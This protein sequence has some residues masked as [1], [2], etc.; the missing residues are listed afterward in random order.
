VGLVARLLLGNGTLTVP[1]RDELAAEGL[2]LLEE[3]LK[4]SVRYDHFK[5]PGRRFNGKVTLVRVA[6]ALSERRVVV[7]ASSG[8]SKLVDSPYTSP[9]FGMVEIARHEDRVE[10]RVDYDKGSDPR[11]G[12]RV[13]I[14]VHTPEAERIVRELT[15]RIGVAGPRSS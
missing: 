13:T 10:F 15:A 5:A 3:D 8:R 2:V 6:L 1:L 12:G 14:R 4:G 11:F 7:Y 9:H